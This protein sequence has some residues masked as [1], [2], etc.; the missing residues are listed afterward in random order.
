[1]NN[2][3]EVLKQWIDENYGGGADFLD[4]KPA[5]LLDM[6]E[7]PISLDG[8]EEKY[9]NIKS[10]LASASHTHPRDEVLIA[11]HQEE[12]MYHTIE[13]ILDAMSEDIW[14]F[15]RYVVQI[16]SDFH[17]CMINPIVPFHEEQNKDDT[18]FYIHA[19]ECALV[20]A[21]E[22]DM[23]IIIEGMPGIE[24]SKIVA[25]ILFHRRIKAFRDF[26]KNDTDPQGSNEIFQP[27]VVGFQTERD[28]AIF[29]ATFEL[30][31]KTTFDK[32]KFLTSFFDKMA[33]YIIGDAKTELDPDHYYLSF[34]HI[35]CHLIGSV[36]VESKNM[37][38]V[39]TQIINGEEPL[40]IIGGKKPGLLNTD[41]IANTI[42]DNGTERKKQF[43][44]TISNGWFSERINIPLVL[45]G[46]VISSFDE[47]F[48]A[49]NA[50]IC[51]KHLWSKTVWYYRPTINDPTYH[52]DKD[53]VER[54]NNILKI[55]KDTP[56]I[57]TD[58]IEE[59]KEA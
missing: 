29:K 52:I 24:Q 36:T 14:Y 56:F 15:L 8:L 34:F 47:R 48:Y 2:S 51:Y 20:Y 43:I 30:M 41:I 40:F 46:G 59:K 50:G 12:L 32:W 22:H 1:M 54:L 19:W 9:Q 25:A 11:Q 17:I 39:S 58:I 21:Y 57:E 13:K 3:F 53:E 23:P 5:L 45:N 49:F 28:A 35:K 18:S 7:K 33:H 38:K 44:A 6:H 27:I 42:I 31:V 16:P 37:Y 55:S 10:I 26:L 4:P